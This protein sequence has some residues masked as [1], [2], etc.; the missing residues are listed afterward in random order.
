MS[1]LVYLGPTPFNFYLLRLFES[2]KINDLKEDFFDKQANVRTWY[3][4]YGK[5]MLKL[6]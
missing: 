5:E 6:L 1:K 3:V 4:G 2:G